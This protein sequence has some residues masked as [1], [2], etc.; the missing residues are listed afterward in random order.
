MDILH[1]GD[2]ERVNRKRTFTCHYCGCVFAAKVPEFRLD[3]WKRLD[4]T[5]L[6][7]YTTCPECGI[8]LEETIQGETVE[9]HAGE[10]GG[11]H[12]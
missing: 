1:H 2:P 7:A 10:S 4:V 11:C 8:Q 6:T 5:V 3:F 12:E 9:S